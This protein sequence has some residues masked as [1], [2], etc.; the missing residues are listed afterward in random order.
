MVTFKVVLT[1]W[2]VKIMG[3]RLGRND[4][5]FCN[6]RKK[7]KNCCLFKE[8]IVPDKAWQR[9]RETEGK[10]IE[11]LLLPFI[12]KHASEVEFAAWCDFWLDSEEV[13][14]EDLVSETAVQ[15]FLPWFLFTW[16]PV[17]LDDSGQ[18]FIEEGF[19]IALQF[20]QKQGY[21][22]SDYEK[23]FIRE[24]CKTHYSFYVVKS[25]LP[26]D[27]M[28]LYDILLNV[29]VTVKEK[30]ASQMLKPGDII[31]TRVFSMDDQAICIGTFPCVIPATFHAELLDIRDGLIKEEGRLTPEILSGELEETMREILFEFLEEIH[32]PTMPQLRNTD[33][34]P[35]MDCTLHYVLHCS[36]DEAAQS[37]LPLTLSKKID[38]YL[39]DAKK[40]KK[41]G[42][43]IRIELPW[44]KRKNKLHKSWENTLLGRVII[45]RDKLTL[46][47]NSEARA[48]KGKQK[49][50][51]YL[52]DQAQFIKVK[53]LPV[54]Q[55]LKKKDKQTA[56]Q[57]T[58][59]EMKAVMEGYLEQY[60]RNWLD[61]SLPILNGLTPREAAK[62]EAGRERLE[63]VL[64]GFERNNL[65]HGEDGRPQV[66]I[67]WLKAEL[68]LK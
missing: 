68:Q 20:L 63:A 28:T 13:W 31:F 10:L 54:E 36:P 27:S 49:I 2:W 48:E 14:P 39:I 59:A 24:L 46:E 19:S 7:L 17:D 38:E 22:M 58:S 62:T 66:N 51:K 30:R 5:C 64:L 18:G 16:K 8:M 60:Y 41:T 57:A 9:M 29:G 3:N 61:E 15:L 12:R 21:K 43:L 35:L 1:F 45:H 34:D 65:R 25:V 44:L 42:A 26:S 11:G 6:S 55:L 4:L 67:E 53:K 50:L 37:L 33:G 52:G 56:E 47:V 40:N 23:R 32:H